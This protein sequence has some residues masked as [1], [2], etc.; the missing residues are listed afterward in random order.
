MQTFPESFLWGAA[1][2]A[3]QIEGAAA[4]D[5]R[6]PSIWDVFSQTP[7][8]TFNGDNGDVACDHYH[9]VAGDVDLMRELNLQ[10]Y[11]F[12]VSWPRVLP[13]GR[14]AVNSPGLDFYDRLVDRLRAADIEPFVTLYHWDLPAALQMELGGWLNPDLPAIFA[15]YADLLYERLGDRVNYWLTLNEPWCV[16]D[17][18][19]FAGVHAP[20]VRN[21]QWGYRV[22]HNLLRAHAYA[23]ARYRASRHGRG[24]ISFALN[25]EFAFPASDSPDDRA[26]ALRA[27]LGFGGW[28][29]DPACFGDYPAVMRERLGDSLPIFA[30]DDARLLKGS[31]DYVALNYYKSEVVR[32]A[33]GGG[34][35]EYECV[36]TDRPRTALDWPIAPD[37]FEK[38]LHW[39][40]KRYPSLP[41]YITENGA[42]FD[43]TPAADGSVNDVDRIAYLH[44]HLS[45]VRAAMADGVD[46]RGYLAWSL[47][48][49][50]EWACGYSKR[51]GLIRCD[52]ESQQR[53]IKS[54]GRWYADVIGSGQLAGRTPGRRLNV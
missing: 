3:Y 49:N 30:D 2:A 37:G 5:G 18:G 52:Y 26:A 15:D 8:K 29:A 33:A 14:G 17:G 42:C 16:V 21:R 20:G 10:A 45:A 46:V 28:F 34:P 51:F 11:R 23:V 40:A 53:T 24:S 43:D 38:L 32:H 19:Y 25:T 1:T 39:L 54:S 35:L 27:M 50:F 4:V 47:L 44:D 22:G 7:G 36:A 12:S 41:I 31:M 48:D 13:A 9:R 6:G